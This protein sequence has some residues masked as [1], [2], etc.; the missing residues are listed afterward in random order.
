VQ[1][2]DSLHQTVQFTDDIDQ[3]VS[4]TQGK[5]DV[6]RQDIDVTT[7]DLGDYLSRPVRIGSYDWRINTSLRETINPWELFLNDSAVAARTRNFSYFRGNMHVKAIINGNSFY[8]GRSLL[9][10]NP[11]GSADEVSITRASGTNVLDDNAEFSQRPHVFLD[12]TESIGGEMALPFFWFRNWATLSN[13]GILGELTLSSMNR[14]RHANGGLDSVT[15]TIFAWM[16]EVELAAPTDF[17]ESQASDEYGMGVISKPATALA[18]IARKLERVPTVRPYATATALAAEGTG[19]LASLFGYSRPQNVSPITK[20]RPT[21]LGNMA[22]TEIA[23]ALDKLSFDPKQELTIDPTVT[24]YAGGDDMSFQAFK[25]RE[26]YFTHFDW[27]KTQDTDTLLFS[28]RVNPTMYA[29]RNTEIHTTPTSFMAQ[30]FKSWRGGLR[31]RLQIVASAF[32]KGRLRIVYDPKGGDVHDSFNT[33]YTRIVDISESRNIEFDIGWNRDKPYLDTQPYIF[34]EPYTTNA[35]TPI[36]INEKT[37]NGVFY[38][39]VM[40]QLVVP[41]DEDINNPEVNVYIKACDDFEVANPTGKHIN[42]LSYFPLTPRPESQGGD[43]MAGAMPQGGQDM[44]T[45]SIG[46]IKSLP[47]NT[48]IHFGEA[49]ATW[50]S[51]LKRYNLHSL[52]D[53]IPHSELGRYLDTNTFPNFPAYRGYD[54]NGTATDDRGPLNYTKLTLLNY[55]APAYAARRGGLRWKF[56]VSQESQDDILHVLTVQRSDRIAAAANS[57]RAGTF[58]DQKIDFAPSLMNGAYVTPIAV[59]PTAEVE[60]PYYSANRFEANR[61]ISGVNTTLH[62]EQQ[63]HDVTVEFDR[64]QNVRNTYYMSKY[65]STGEDFNLIWFVN[66]PVT[67]RYSLFIP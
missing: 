32:H 61:A 10:Y 16:T 37:D 38:V 58:I 52:V 3:S 62:N 18:R 33:V 54:P 47:G 43:E 15:I 22:N 7:T 40:N 41:S 67:Y 50:R 44:Q 60:F 36:Q 14:L 66:T 55:L 53:S 46:T 21:Y 30:P 29:E 27:K 4:W 51:L 35:V 34:G 39:Y 8:Y 17:L 28:C 59:N 5:V 23:E 12:P 48:L 13:P 20:Y 65:C 11:M 56:N 42:T 2:T 45:E 64:E 26:S 57:I 1:P 24:G 25:D 63:F 9:S 31:F 49:Y 6:E 19:R